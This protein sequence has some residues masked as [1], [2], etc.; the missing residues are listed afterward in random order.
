MSDPVNHPAHYFADSPFEV[1][2]VLNAWLTPEEFRGYCKGN[3]HKYLARANAK[4]RPAE[5]VAKARWYAVALDEFNQET[6]K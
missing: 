3:I 2:R 6:S 5:D 1:I 4:G